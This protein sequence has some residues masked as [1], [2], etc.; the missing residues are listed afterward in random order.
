MGGFKKRIRKEEGVD[1]TALGIQRLKLPDKL[2]R[3]PPTDCGAMEILL[4]IVQ[5]VRS[6]R[7]EKFKL[8]LARVGAI[9]MDDA[10]EH[11]E[12][13]S[14]R[15]QVYYFDRELHQEAATRGVNSMNEHAALIDANFAGL[16]LTTGE[17]SLIRADRPGHLPGT[18]PETMGS[19]ELAANIF[20]RAAAKGV[21]ADRD[22]HGVDAITAAAKEVGTEIRGTLARIGS[23]MPEDMPQYPPLPP[24]EWM[25]SDH[26]SR[27]D[28]DAPAELADGDDASQ[29]IT[30]IEI[31]GP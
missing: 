22:L 31:V 4:R 9:V 10:Q 20:Q 25:P 24:G 15:T 23:A 3:M 29:H 30:V 8:W 7:A 5:S 2:G 16:Y 6:P 17:V 19:V 27:I 18:L 26:P 21:I 28:W 11:T 13:V 1:V 12:R 14:H